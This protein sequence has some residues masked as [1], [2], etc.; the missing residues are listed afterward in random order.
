M[1]FFSSDMKHNPVI[2]PAVCVCALVDLYCFYFYVNHKK[3]H[4]NVSVPKQKICESCIS[5]L[6]LV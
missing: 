2:D 4:Y 1:A 5:K 3:N 6:I